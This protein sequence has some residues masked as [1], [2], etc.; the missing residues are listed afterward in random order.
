MTAPTAELIEE[1]QFAE[2]CET[3]S[4]ECPN[5]ATWHIWCSHHQQGCDMYGYRCD[6]HFNLLLLET[7]RLVAF[8]KFGDLVL[9]AECGKRIP[10]DQQKV[11][12]HL[13]G[14]RI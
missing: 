14:I 6:I 1:F 4:T 5:M 11:S 2:P 9:C 13:R 3:P 10:N 7:K 12:D 8:L